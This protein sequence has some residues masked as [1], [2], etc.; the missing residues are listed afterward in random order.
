MNEG[1]E[2]FSPTHRLFLDQDALEPLL[3]ERAL[4]LGAELRNRVEAVGARAQDDDG[5]TVTLRRPRRR[6]AEHGTR[7]VRR[8]RRRQPQ[9][10]AHA[11]GH[12]DGGLRAAVAQH[13]DLLP[14]GLRAA[15]AEPQ[16]GRHLRPQPDA[17]RVLP[18]RPDGRQGL[19]RRQ[20]RRRGRHDG[21]GG[22]RRRR[23]DRGARPG[24]A[25][26]ARSA[27]PTCP[28]R[29]STSPTG[30]RRPTWRRGSP[31]D[32]CSSP[33]TPRTSSRPTAASA[34]TPESRTPT[35]SRG[36]SPPSCKGE[37]GPALL[38]TYD[39]ERRPLGR[40]TIE[41]AYTRYATRVVPS[42]ARRA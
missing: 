10:D 36:S 18:A 21:G 35:T 24:A 12:R 4:E 40:M 11:S 7:A 27:R 19:P 6:H 3:R 9:P 41:Q 5:V 39:A 16:P 13:H 34:A 2:G 8:R 42:A 33:A 28:W 17:A 25:G 26:H 20:H 14:R 22:E 15:A 32:A 37:A 30:R 31:T 23:H 1:V 29:S 38:D